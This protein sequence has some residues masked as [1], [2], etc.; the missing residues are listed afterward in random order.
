MAK[1]TLDDAMGSVAKSLREFGY[2]DVTAKMVREIYDAYESG[3]RFPDLPHGVVGGF[4][5]SQ[6][7]DVATELKA[8]PR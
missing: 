8:L 5:E 2:P 7:N 3:K 1:Y 4:A 6:F